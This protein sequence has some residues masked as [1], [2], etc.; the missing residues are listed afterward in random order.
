MGFGQSSFVLFLR[1]CQS[2]LNNRTKR[3]QISYLFPNGKFVLWMMLLADM[4]QLIQQLYGKTKKSSPQP[5]ISMFSVFF[6]LFQCLKK[7]HIFLHASKIPTFL[8]DCEVFLDVGDDNWALFYT[9]SRRVSEK[10]GFIN[11][12]FSKYVVQLLRK[13]RVLFRASDTL[14]YAQKINF[15]RRL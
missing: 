15:S 6:M 5:I 7:N 9:F 3:F 12:F 4:L 1:W 13:L 10:P 14:T 2:K 8:H 11:N